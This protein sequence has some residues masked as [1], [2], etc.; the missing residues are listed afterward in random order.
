M[1]RSAAQKRRRAS[2]A[3]LDPW[4]T[5]EGGMMLARQE[6]GLVA[7]RG[8]EQGRKS[9]LCSQIQGEALEGAW[10][11]GVSQLQQICHGS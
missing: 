5:V 3:C 6:A 10:P 4:S 7:Q 9:I 11:T 1:E 8:M 2:P